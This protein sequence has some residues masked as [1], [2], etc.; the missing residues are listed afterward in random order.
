MR[1]SAGSVDGAASTG[2]SAR[3]A[4]RVVVLLRGSSDDGGSLGLCRLRILGRLL[5]SVGLGLSGRLRSSRGLGVGSFLCLLRVLRSLG[6]S[7]VLCVLRSLSV[8]GGFGFGGFLRVG[9]GLGLRVGLCL[10][11]GG[12]VGGGLLRGVRGLGGRDRGVLAAGQLRGVV[13]GA[14]GD[15]VGMGDRGR[16]LRV[17]LDAVDGLGDRLVSVGD[18][19]ELV[20]GRRSVVLCRIASHRQRSSAR[21]SRMRT[22]LVRVHRRDVAL[23]DEHP[24]GVLLRLDAVADRGGDDL[25][26]RGER[27][28]VEG[29][30]GREVGVGLGLAARV[31]AGVEELGVVLG[32]A[33][34]GQ[35]PEVCRK[36]KRKQRSNRDEGDRRRTVL[37]VVLEL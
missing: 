32:V 22:D 1:A 34:D 18:G 11:F 31:A 6:R 27:V 13:V 33:A 4:S 25:V 19:V 5:L 30:L 17:V 36:A 14:G 10:G 35:V 37:V 7:G 9:G 8:S 2:A 12:G 29:A 3:G 15:L 28:G 23:G 24:L 26:G 21:A 16:V 20:S